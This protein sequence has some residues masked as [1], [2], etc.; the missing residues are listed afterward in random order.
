MSGHKSKKR[1]AGI[2]VKRKT[3]ECAWGTHEYKIEKAGV[4][5]CLWCGT[6]KG[7]WTGA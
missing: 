7:Y 5:V 2:P 1:R 3:Y 4:M 6:R